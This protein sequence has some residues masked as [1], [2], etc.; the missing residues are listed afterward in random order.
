MI[1][2]HLL[3]YFPWTSVPWV[4][5]GFHDLDT[6]HRAFSFWGLEYNRPRKHINMHL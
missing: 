1:K 3:S 5:L 2:K 4:G 6:Y